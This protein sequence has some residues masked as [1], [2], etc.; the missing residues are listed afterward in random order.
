MSKLVVRLVILVVATAAGVWMLGSTLPPRIEALPDSSGDH[1]HATGGP[2][3]RHRHGHQAPTGPERDH[4][5]GVQ[6]SAHHAA[7]SK[8]ALVVMDHLAAAGASWLRVD[9]GWATLQPDGP[10]PFAGWYTDLLDDVLARAHRLGLKVILALWQTPA[11][12]S[13]SGSP[14]APPTHDS[15]F[16]EA[17]G[18]AAQRWG[19]DVDAWEVWNE[20]NFDAFFEGADPATYT[21]LLCAAYPAVKHYDQSPVLLG[22]LMYNDDDW[23][24]EAYEAGAKDCFDGV[25]THP[26]VGPSNAPPDTPAVGAKWRLTA[27]PAVRDVMKEY[28]D[29]R[30]QIWITEL[31]WSSGPDSKGNPWDIPVSPQ[32]QAKFLRQAV[33]LVRTRYPYVGPIIW[34]RDVDGRS[35]SYQ[36]GFGLFHPDLTPKPALGAFEAAVRGRGTRRAGRS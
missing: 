33:E 28:G 25:A 9:V 21:R 10:G 19:D 27:T 30:K 11:W 36:D 32:T 31:G 13:T 4:E 26:Y 8:R 3:H 20:P 17:I 34:Y 29:A 22:G 18:T 6:L 7:T 14:Y 16:A 23:L 15:D 1:Q 5:L 35:R 24:R 12:A 2:D